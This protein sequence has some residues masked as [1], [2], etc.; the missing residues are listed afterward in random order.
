MS[1]MGGPFVL[2]EVIADSGD[3]I[4]E[5]QKPSCSGRR[6]NGSQGKHMPQNH[7]LFGFGQ[8]GVMLQGIVQRAPGMG[9]TVESVG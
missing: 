4:V 6:R 8:I 7:I 2:A 3:F 5:A 9:K 1:A